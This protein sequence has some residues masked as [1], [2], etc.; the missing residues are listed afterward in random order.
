MNMNNTLR[1]NCATCAHC[2]Y[3]HSLG[4]VCGRDGD[5]VVEVSSD[6]VC[7]H[8]K[9]KRCRDCGH[10]F[11]PFGDCANIAL[12]TC[13]ESIDDDFVEIPKDKKADGCESYYY[14]PQEEVLE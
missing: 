7:P 11:D 13:Y 6:H 10:Y 9:E 2:G 5:N 3:I 14:D 8:W 1:K 12:C 4:L